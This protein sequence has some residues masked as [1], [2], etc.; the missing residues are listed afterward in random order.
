MPSPSD[1]LRVSFAADTD[2][3]GNCALC[4]MDYTD[5]PCP[6]PTMDELYEYRLGPGGVLQARLKAEAERG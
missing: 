3:D 1:W 6:G 2:E 5:C 4:G